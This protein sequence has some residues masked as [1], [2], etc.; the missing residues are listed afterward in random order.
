LRKRLEDEKVMNM[1][2][3]S[4]SDRQRQYYDRL[5]DEIIARRFGSK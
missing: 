2:L 1:D 3:S 4:M 5:Q